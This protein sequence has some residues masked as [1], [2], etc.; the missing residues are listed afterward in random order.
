MTMNKD[1]VYYIISPFTARGDDAERVENLRYLQQREF[2]HKLIMQGY[3]TIAPIEMCYH[4][5]LVYG[6]TGEYEFWQKRDRALIKVSDGVIVFKMDGWKESKGVQD[7]IQYAESLG[8]EVHYL[9]PETG[10]IL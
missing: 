6:L 3:T 7:E 9:N 2:H 1:K 4:I 10:K 8:K 5:H